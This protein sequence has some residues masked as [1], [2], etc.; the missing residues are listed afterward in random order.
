MVG[1]PITQVSLSV[2][3]CAC[4]AG[5]M[6]KIGS[7]AKIATVARLLNAPRCETPEAIGADRRSAQSLGISSGDG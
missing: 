7:G 6:L 2:R 5:V 1:M 3:Y 4:L